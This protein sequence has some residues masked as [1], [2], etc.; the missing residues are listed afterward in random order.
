MNN[1]VIPLKYKKITVPVVLDYS[2]Y[3]RI[4]NIIELKTFLVNDKG[5]IYTFY[6]SE[7]IYLHD[8]VLRL[9]NKKIVNMP[10][11]HINK[12]NMDCRVK[13]LMY[14]DKNKDIN[15]NLNKKARTI[16]LP[17]NSKINVDEIPTFV[18]YLKP[19]ISHGERFMV[20]IDDIIWKSTSQKDLSL[21]YKL[22]ETK[23]FLRTLKKHRP[24]IFKRYSLNGDLNIFGERLKDEYYKII[25]E[26]NF[27][28]TFNKTVNTDT[29]LK[30]NLNHL[31]K[32]EI[33][34]LNSKTF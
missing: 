14:D 29:L 25:N 21:R 32:N 9:H 4:N 3:L 31:S 7:L 30:E 17:K 10:I 24:D 13:N 6:N 12:L 28:Y 11:I 22:E 1:I 15:K 8:I 26:A 18:W 20:C 5:H 19:D 2:I 33:F 16:I 27:N 23:K 34:L